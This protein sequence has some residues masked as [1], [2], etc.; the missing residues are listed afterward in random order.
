MYALSGIV[1]VLLGFGTRGRSLKELDTAL[2]KLRGA[3]V[4]PVSAR[5]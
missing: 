1:F 4:Q 3:S 5:P 2:D